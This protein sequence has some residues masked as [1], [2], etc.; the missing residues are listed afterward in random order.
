MTPSDQSLRPAVDPPG[1]R[2]DERGEDHQRRGREDDHRPLLRDPHG[3]V[4]CAQFGP[5]VLGAVAA[6]HVCHLV[7]P[8][9]F[10]RGY[11]RAEAGGGA[12]RHTTER[13]AGDA[14]PIVAPDG[15][16]G[17]KGRAACPQAGR[18]GAGREGARRAGRAQS[19]G[20]AP[21][22]RDGRLRRRDPPPR[23]VPAARPAPD[24]QGARLRQPPDR[25]DRGDHRRRHLG[26]PEHDLPAAARPGGAG[27]DQGPVGASRTGERAASTRSPPRGARSTGGWSPSWSRS[28]T[29]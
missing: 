4:R 19:A 20:A 23:R 18:G 24:L 5:L 28:S 15:P 2:V 26:Q 14:R 29:R 22:R 13:R 8:V 25:G 17:R 6:G 1:R 12:P 3:P 9:G 27:P 7:L 11:T 16:W 10:R 21:R